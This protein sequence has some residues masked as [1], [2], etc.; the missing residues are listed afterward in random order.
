MTT[1]DNKKIKLTY[2]DIEGAGEPVRLALVLSGTEFEDDRIKF[3]D[4]AALK[5]KTPNGQLP[6]MTIGD[7][8]TLRTQ[9]AAM[10]RYVG[11][12]CSPDGSLYPRDKLYDVEEVL[13]LLDD[14]KRD[15]NGPFYL[16][17]AP[18]KFGYPQDYNK[19]DE[20]K[21]LLK[22]MREQFVQETLPQHLDRLTKL[23]EKS[24]DK[25]LVA[26]CDSPTIADCAWVPFLRNYT[27]GHIDY[28][29]VKCLD[30][31]PKVVEYVKRFCDLPSIKGRY[32]SG[33]GS[34]TS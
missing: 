21:A 12:E 17:M 1:S 33:L 25:W 11:A 7:D 15:W 23:L 16:G 24:G 26:G 29:D 3:P 5:P 10:L 19:T 27:R 9:S 13:G 14:A 30:G 2:F 6:V 32:T 22:K 28:V 34:S 8:P 31:H 4:W 18:T 20:G